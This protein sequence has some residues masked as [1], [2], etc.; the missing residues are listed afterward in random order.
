MREVRLDPTHERFPAAC[1]PLNIVPV[2][3]KPL[4]KERCDPLVVLDDEE[5]HAGILTQNVAPCPGRLRTPAAP[6]CAEGPGRPLDRPGPSTRSAI[7][8]PVGPRA[9]AHNDTSQAVVDSQ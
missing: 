8:G 5:L 4:R 1:H 9:R 7:D 3:P 2:R 6:P